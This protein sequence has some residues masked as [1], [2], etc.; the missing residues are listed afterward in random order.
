MRWNC[1]ECSKQSLRVFQAHHEQVKAECSRRVLVPDPVPGRWKRPRPEHAEGTAQPVKDPFDEEDHLP[2]TSKRQA[3]SASS[4]PAKLAERFGSFHESARALANCLQKRDVPRETDQSVIE[5]AKWMFSQIA[6]GKGRLGSSDAT[7][8][9]RS[10]YR[11]QTEQTT[12]FAY[13]DIES[14]SFSSP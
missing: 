14:E 2:Q 4:T 1:S 11:D 12:M 9:R 10:L 3:T 13:R 5:A 6:G 7:V 8:T